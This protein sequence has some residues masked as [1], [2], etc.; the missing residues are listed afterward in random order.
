MKDTG[1]VAYTKWWIAHPWHTTKDMPVPN[2]CDCKYCTKA[3]TEK[4]KRLIIN[5]AA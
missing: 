2:D 4:S 3:R 5:P 1:M